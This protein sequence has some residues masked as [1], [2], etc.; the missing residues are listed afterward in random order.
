MMHHRRIL[1]SDVDLSHEQPLPW[2]VPEVH[3]WFHD[4]PAL[5]CRVSRS[6]G[7]LLRVQADGLIVPEGTPVE[8]QWT[9]DDRGCYAAGTVIAAPPSGPP[10]LYLRVDES[11]SGIERRI[12]VRL[13]VQLPASV[14][15]P[16]GRVL[17]GRTTD[18]SLGGASI[19]ADSLAC[20]GF[21]GD[22]LQPERDAPQ[23][24]ASVVLALPTGVATLACRVISVSGNT[25]QVRVRF[26]HH[27]GL[28]IEQIGA[29]LS[30][31]QRR[32]ALRRDVPS[33][34]DK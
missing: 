5:N 7:D 3:I 28:V 1:R 18:L 27:D 22:F 8:I 10:G 30:A 20:G 21:L 12:G 26:V 34:L 2:N 11:V 14:I 31:E 15:A 29:L 17:P 4:G 33:R 23:A 25:G 32:I 13:P 24:R 9:Q 19:V 16:S 6:P